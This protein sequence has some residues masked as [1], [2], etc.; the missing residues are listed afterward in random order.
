[1]NRIHKISKD[2]LNHFFINAKQIVI[3]DLFCID[4]KYLDLLDYTFGP[5]LGQL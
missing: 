3:D 4:K 2:C 5:A 1:M